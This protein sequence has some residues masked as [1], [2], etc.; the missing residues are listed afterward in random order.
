LDG[1]EFIMNCD[2]YTTNAKPATEIDVLNTLNE[3]KKKVLPFE[4]LFQNGN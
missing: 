1:F 4:E 2:V 3:V